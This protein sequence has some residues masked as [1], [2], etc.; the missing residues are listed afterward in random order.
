MVL[1]S[2]MPIHTTSSFDPIAC[3]TTNSAWGALT[4]EVLSRLGVET[5][6]SSPGSRSTPLTVAAVRNSKLECLSVLDER[7]AAFFALGLAKRT[8]RPV[9]L[10]CTSGSAAANY[11]PAIVEASMGGVP[12]LILTADRPPEMRDCSS[13]QTIDQLKLYGDYVRGFSEMALPETSPE[14]L[15]YLRQRLVFAVST[16]LGHDSGPV[17]LNFP[18]RDPLVPSV[19]TQVVEPSMLE[20]AATTLTR[21]S[22]AV[23]I[24]SAVDAVALERLSSHQCGIILVGDVNPRGDAEEFVD[25]IALLSER[26]GWPVISDVLNPLRCN[27]KS[28][29]KLVTHYEHF[30]RNSEIAADLKPSAILQIGPLPT[31]KVLRQWVEAL[32]AV[33]YLVT[34]RPV[35]TDPLHRVATFLDTSAEG[36]AGIIEQQSVDSKWFEKW[37]QAEQTAEAGIA[38]RIANADPEFEGRIAHLLSTC[39]PECSTVFFAS[40]MSVRYAEYFWAKTNRRFAIYGNRGANGIDGTLG[41]ALGLAHRGASTFLLTGDLAFLH[42]SNALLISN[43]LKG[44]LT[45]ILINNSGGGIFEHLPIAAQ[46]PP[47]EDYFATPQTIDFSSLCQ[48][49]GVTHDL[50]ASIDQL[51]PLVEEKASPGVHVL[52]VI[53][54]RKS[55]VVSLRTILN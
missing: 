33:S 36:L 39:L 1:F 26:L 43:Q 3:S 16:A 19:E 13:G 27:V 15:A 2:M 7:S 17:H 32:D 49:H 18:F 44:S 37:N 38:E 47:F 34:L 35:N 31:S 41:T 4:M 50:V 40:S 54:N 6:V 52:E 48:A 24:D 21:P 55:D 46:N 5:V 53:T 29:P 8:W 12:L 28:V 42:D 20:A 45:V 9:V 10:V 22:E 11:L 30:L 25:A 23:R 51:V 14:M